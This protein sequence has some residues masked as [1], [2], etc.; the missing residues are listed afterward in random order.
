M[1]LAQFIKENRE[2]IDAVIKDACPNCKIKSDEERRLWMI[3]DEGLHL[4]A[5]RSGVSDL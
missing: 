1:T 5:E 4:W 3:N 2:Q